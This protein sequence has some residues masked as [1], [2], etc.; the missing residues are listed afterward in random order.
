VT[1]AGP[2]ED[3][4][5]LIVDDNPDNVLLLRRILERAGYRHI[6]TTTDAREVVPAFAAFDPDI[7]LLDL[8]MPH[9]LGFEIMELLRVELGDDIYLPIL[10]LTAD[11]SIGS[12]DAALRGGAHDFVT[13]P[14]DAVEVL[15]RIR[16]LLHTRQLHVRLTEKSERQGHAL[17]TTRVEVLERLALAAE[18]RDNETHVHTLRVGETTAALAQAIGLPAHEIEVLRRAAPLHDI[19]KIGISDAVLL[20]PGKLT[21]EEFAH[22]QTHSAVG[23]H[24]LAD[25]DIPI[26][27]AAQ[28]IALTHHE[29]WDGSGYPGR[30][31]GA[32]IPLSGRIVAVADVF[33]A[34]THERP[35]KQ[36]WSIE[37]AIAEM[38]SLRAQH[39]DPEIIDVF[40]DLV[41]ADPAQF[42]V[43]EAVLASLT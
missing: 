22:I 42:A 9:L 18:L 11:A 8:H 32:D 14:F 25:S 17:E 33:D 28:V 27:Q 39:F 3:A 41:E 24:L 5:I 6:K 40:A 43:D 19:G 26:I 37:H 21:E 29:R 10:V 16:N 7:L 15:L 31:S 34:L 23:A 20:K 13:K 12:R 38:R 4:R 35:Y 1:N 30:L 36:A 2:V